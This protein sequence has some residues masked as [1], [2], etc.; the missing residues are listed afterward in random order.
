MTDHKFTD[1]EIIHSLKVCS[2]DGD[3][4]ECKINPHKG[5]YGYCTSL[6]IKAALDL[7]NRQKAE[8]E[9]LKDVKFQ[10]EILQK[11]YDEIEQQLH[12][13]SNVEI[14]YLY[15]FTEDKDKKLETIANI[16]LGARAK[17]IK[18]FAERL[19]ANMS[20]IAR[21]EF[22]GNIYFCVG[23]DLIDTLVKE[24]TEEQTNES[25]ST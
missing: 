15:S 6:A 17:A 25:Q 16:L 21:M 12:Y 7:I 14:P 2:T 1:D 3:C 8:I 10:Y 5:N 4:S 19:K 11:N 18:E 24:M 23:Y 13:L 9:R 22:G 20:N